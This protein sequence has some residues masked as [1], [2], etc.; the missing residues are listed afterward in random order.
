MNKNYPNLARPINLRTE[1]FNTH[2]TNNSV[3]FE[4]GS[5]GNTLTEAINGAKCAAQAVA[6]VLMES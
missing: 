2:L 6:D 1:R 5:N 3:I 4:I